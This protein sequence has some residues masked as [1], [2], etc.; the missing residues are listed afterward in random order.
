MAAGG[1][2]QKKL[3]RETQLERDNYYMRIALSV[4]ERADC[5]GTEIGAVIVRDDRVISTGVNGTPTDYENCR[6]G[7][8]LRCWDSSLAKH[9]RAGEMTDETHVSGQRLD[10]C[11]CVHA[12]ENALLAAARFGIA[13]AGA[14]IYTTYKPCGTCLRL[15]YQAQLKRIVYKHGYDQF[16][17]EDLTDAEPILRKQYATLVDLLCAG[18]PDNFDELV[19]RPKRA[20]P[21]QPPLGGRKA[22]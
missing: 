17:A 22:A 19:E 13:V 4:S 8:C 3:D 14:T 6:D 10:R 12:E 18:D 15:C 21:D 20:R 5:F 2:D 16:D 1:A 7:G 9:G 11:I